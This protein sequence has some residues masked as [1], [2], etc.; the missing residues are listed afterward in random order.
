MANQRRLWRDGKVVA[1]RRPAAEAALGRPMELPDHEYSDTERAA[2]RAHLD[3]LRKRDA[4]AKRRAAGRK[5][6]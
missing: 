1:A 3:R 6:S 5:A 4:G 2:G